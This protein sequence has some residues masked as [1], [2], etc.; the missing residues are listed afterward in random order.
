[1]GHSGA[2]ALAVPLSDLVLCPRLEHLS[3]YGTLKQEY[4]KYLDAREYAKALKFHLMHFPMKLSL[5][6]VIAIIGDPPATVRE[7][8]LVTVKEGVTACK[9]IE[10]SIMNGLDC[11]DSIV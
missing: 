8:G 3:F 5:D 2:H 4:Q 1:M 7:D 6:D 9:V 10:V 11:S